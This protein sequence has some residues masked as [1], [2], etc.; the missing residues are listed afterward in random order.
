MHYQ[1]SEDQAA[2]ATGALLDEL[3]LT[4]YRPMDDE[5]DPRPL[6]E[7][8]TCRQSLTDAFD[9]IAAMFED[10]RLEEETSDILWQFTNLFHKKVE[11]VTRQLDSNELAQRQS[12]LEQNG[13]EVRSV[14]LEKLTATGIA[15]VEQRNAFEFIREYSSDLF[16]RHTG[17]SW[18]PV[19]GSVVNRKAV[20]S[21]MIDSRDFINA[22]AKADAAVLAPQGAL[23]LFAAGPDYND[24][25]KIWAALDKVR[26][27]HPDMV[28]G[29]GASP[30]GGER[31][32]ACWAENRKVPQV[33]FKPDWARHQKAAPFKRN[34]QMLSQMPVG[35]VHGPGNGITMNLVDKAIKQGLPTM[36]LA[37]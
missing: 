33:P 34:D 8:D 22:R 25:D 17:S 37:A 26:E 10:T 6:P 13:S 20:T 31:I 15:L 14:E 21:A 35:L 24:H 19:S 4:G 16:S 32:A 23:I 27:K 11:R 36:K 2:S 29:H 18:R 7:A 28:L 12:V 30:K 9:A 5:H 3:A 1:G